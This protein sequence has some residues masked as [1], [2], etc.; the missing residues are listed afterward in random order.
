VATPLA[1]LSS[2]GSG[3]QKLCDWVLAAAIPV[4]MHITTNACVT[5][6]VP[7][8]FR[9]ARVFSFWVLVGGGGG[10]RGKGRACVILRFA[11][12]QLS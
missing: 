12:P 1:A 11:L 4:H 9:G 2:K 5:D 8:R 7:T 10:N 3:T 6:Y